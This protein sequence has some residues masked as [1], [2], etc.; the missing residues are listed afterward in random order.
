VK[1]VSKQRKL[2]EIVI[3]AFAGGGGTSHGIQLATGRSPHIAVNHCHE[4]LKMHAANHRQTRHVEEDIFRIAPEE[5]TKGRAA[6][7]AC[8]SPDCF[9]AGTLVLTADGYLPIEE[10]HV[11]DLVFTHRGRWRR[12]IETMKS[13]KPVRTIRGHGHPGLSVSGEHPF[14][15]MHRTNAFRQE[16]RRYR[17]IFTEPRWINAIDLQPL[18]GS[19]AQ[20]SG[21]YWSTPL[22]FEELPVPEVGGRGMKLDEKFFWLVGRYLADGWSRIT[23]TRAELVIICGKH[24]TEGLQAIL[25]AWPRSAE[26]AGFNE[27]SWH[28]RECE[29]AYQF[30]TNHR[31]LV[32]WL[33][34]NFGHLAHEKRIPGWALGMDGGLRAA[35][36]A[37]YLSGDGWKSEGFMECGTVSRAL[38]FGIKSL[39]SSL[40]YTVSVYLGAKNSGTIEGRVVNIRPNYRLRWR[41]QVDADHEQ[42]V[43]DSLH[44]FTPI[45]EIEPLKDE[46]VEV[47]NIGVEEDESYVV[48]GIV[49]HNCRHFSSALG[50][51]KRSPR[52]RALAWSVVW[53]AKRIAPRVIIVENVREFLTW[54]PLLDDG[55]P[56]P[57][58]KGQTF[59]AWVR[60]LRREGYVVEW[61][62]LDAADYGVPTHRRRL[63]IVARKDG[64]PIEWPAPTH[65]SPK[66]IA[67][68]PLIFFG[69]K[70]HVPAAACID[71]SIP[72]PSIF[73]RKKPL[74][75]ATLRRIALGVK[76]YV[77]DAA[78]PFL[79]VCNHGGQEFRGQ[80]LGEP[81]PTVTASRDAHGL[82]TPFMARI[83]QTGGNGKF[84]NDLREPLTTI[85]SKAE[86]LLVV[87]TLIQTGYGEREGQAPR[88][89]GLEKPL[90]TSVNGQKHALVAAFLAKHF[91]GVVGCSIDKP[92]PT[93]T[94]IPTQNQIVAANLIRFNFDDAG[95]PLDKPAPTATVSN[96]AAL[97]AAN[98]IHLNHAAGGKTWSAVDEPLRTTTTA[99]H[100]FLVYSFLSKYFGT[101]IG[102]PVDLPMGTATGKDRFGLVTVT[103]DGELWVIV[104]IG[105][106][107]LSPRELARAN[108][109][110]DSYL[111]TGSKSNQVAR[112]GN[113]V[114]PPV[115]EALVRANYT[116]RRVRV[117]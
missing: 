13:M 90:G 59:K 33:R 70:P 95:I 53:Y 61:R 24:E 85:T 97:V 104:D 18:S 64:E 69:R 111:L 101:A 55:Q 27:L 63:F 113:S 34:A 71:W 12:V 7:L 47:F 65:A 15:A 84:A 21:H 32:E 28:G 50:G 10:V 99:N 52:V 117:G 6:G 91:G 88:V 66:D 38:A 11:G 26:R 103:I 39:A 51:A 44:R 108:G 75:E 14:W 40:G 1:V 80:D 106:R 30:S 92:L 45:R 37:G 67:E 82:V 48:E 81:M 8:F 112:I 19:Q 109:F 20:Q 41:H 74:A 94:A 57:A 96:H 115:I 79:V 77:L 25:N 43:A 86:H 56:D 5:L 2:S 31:G 54:G 76:R 16:I 49:V 116:P 29:T 46:P 68:R 35:L 98:L 87:P 110:P 9:P 42:T 93:I 114:P 36:L 60:A 58:K 4:A 17:P 102:Q 100:A 107:M 73:E 22:N 23:S 78:K 105:M 3:D 89:P 83:G 72:C 62:I